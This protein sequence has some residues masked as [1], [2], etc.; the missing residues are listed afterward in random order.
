MEQFPDGIDRYAIMASALPSVSLVRD[1]TIE[2]A[3]SLGFEVAYRI[4][5]QTQGET[6]WGNFVREMQQADIKI[7]EF[8]GQPQNLVALTQQLDIARWRSEDGRVGK[9]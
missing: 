8:I 6:G 3:E 9:K 2:V 4:D 1:Q 7:L 5:Y